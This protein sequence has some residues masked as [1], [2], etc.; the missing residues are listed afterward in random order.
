MV[1]VKRLSTENVNRMFKIRTYNN[2]SSKGLDLFDRDYFEVSDSV[3]DPDAIVLRSQKLHDETFSD[4]TLA[5]GR[6]G[7]G[8]NN[9]PIDR[10]SEQGIVVFN[11]PG[12]N[13]NAVKE[14]VILGMLLAA[15]NVVPALSFASS[16]KGQGEEVGPAVEKNKSQFVGFELKGKKLGVL[17]LGAIGL[18]VANAAVE[19]GMEVEG[20]DPYLSV[21]RAW[22]LS[23][24]VKPATSLEKML[25]T[26]DFLTVHVPFSD[27]TRSFLNEE[28]IQHL[29]PTAV[30]LNF[31][32]DALVDEEALKV[33]LDAG[34]VARYVT[35]FPTDHLLNHERV[36]SIPHL[37]ASTGEAEENCAVMIATQIKDFVV[38]GNIKNSVNFPDCAMDRVEGATR[39]IVVNK[40][41]PKIIGTVSSIMA[42][43][44]I[45]IV[46]MTN[47]SKGDYAYNII[48]FEGNLAD[49]ALDAIKQVD[50]VIKTRVL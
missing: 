28:R 31:S 13:A 46:E 30:L 45:N 48:D 4:S 47:K 33:A 25:Q 41:V 38:N 37:G 15:R 42:D 26:C 27:K 49:G 7:A 10:C 39:L 22:E 32:R 1:H 43:H 19:L 12:A 29:K 35:D 14:L 8:V 5:I 34:K 44:G 24:S 50:G 18:M 20:Y 21:N 40:N 3:S 6:A 2:I 11:T 9:I 17:G 36:I 23:S 16:L